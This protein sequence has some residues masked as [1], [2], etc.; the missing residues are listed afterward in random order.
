MVINNLLIGMILQVDQFPMLE[1]SNDSKYF[2][3]CVNH[4]SYIGDMVI[5]MF[6]M[7]RMMSW[8]RF[9]TNP[10][11]YQHLRIQWPFCLDFAFSKSCQSPHI[12]IPV[13]RHFEAKRYLSHCC[14]RFVPSSWAG[15]WL[16]HRTINDGHKRLL[17][18]GRWVAWVS[19]HG[20][21]IEGSC[22]WKMMG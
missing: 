19:S 1:I 13:F 9:S 7:I 8:W 4:L 20:E 12:C 22:F 5:Q 18:W 6:N 15:N 10:I 14:P 11:K 2:F 16:K 21:V 3:G 17:F